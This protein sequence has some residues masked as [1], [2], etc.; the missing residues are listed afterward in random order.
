MINKYY[1]IVSLLVVLPF[2]WD[3]YILGVRIFDIIAIVLS[4]VLLLA[5]SRMYYT[6]NIMVVM[7]LPLWCIFYSSIGL[8][9][10]MDVKSFVGLLTGAF[11]YILLYFFGRKTDISGL[12][13]AILMSI[14]LAL[15]AQILVHEIF[16]Y[17]INFHYIVDHSPRLETGVGYRYSGL[18][19]EPSAHSVTVFMLLVV[20]YLY[21]YFGVTEFLAITSMIL[22]MSLWGIVAGVV[23]IMMG[24]YVLLKNDQRFAAYSMLASALFFL[25][26]LAVINYSLVE[27]YVIDRVTSLLGSG[28]GGGQ[29]YNYRYAGLAMLIYDFN[30]SILLGDGL[31]TKRYTAY[32]S[33]GLSFLISGV[34]VLGSTIFF[35]IV[36]LV[37]KKNAFS[38]SLA[39]IFVLTNAYMWTSL[40]FW[41]WLYMLYRSSQDPIYLFKVF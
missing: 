28:G 17:L 32:G 3:Y 36:S 7:L 20:R 11:F 26:V 16:G 21:G 35:L 34:G 39:I 5:S 38:V 14:S 25:A 2:L 6:S 24:V 23:G 29:S 27:Y 18:Y 41:V 40:V 12:A 37:C 9:A 30:I 19:M 8:L 13:K 31:S 10:T 1:K 4:V 15:F 33:S 22:S